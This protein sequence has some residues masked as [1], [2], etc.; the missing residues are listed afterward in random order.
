[1]AKK[2][3]PVEGLP[4]GDDGDEGRNY[5]TMTTR[6]LTEIISRIR[7]LRL[8]P[9]HPFTENELVDELGLSKTPVREALLVLGAYGYVVPRPRTGYRVSAITVKVIHDVC[10]ALRALASEAAAS[11]A[12]KNLD[13][14]AMFILEDLEED[15][16]PR[17]DMDIDDIVNARTQFFRLLTIK[18][19]NQ[20]LFMLFVQLN[21]DFS[22]AIHLA[23]RNGGLRR[24]PRGQAEVLAALAAKDPEAARLA[25]R[26]LVDAWEEALVG[27][28]LES[29]AVLSVNV[30]L[31]AKVKP[32]PKKTAKKRAAR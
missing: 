26:N 16:T 12:S 11:A 8:A 3:G 32:K 1:M 17:T 4:G 24:R 23:L 28:M 22:R 6:A 31:P 27:A 18:A 7:D 13:G 2:P 15:I 21:N 25:M 20:R 14:N 5:D 9:G 29:D 19:E 30:S 10:G